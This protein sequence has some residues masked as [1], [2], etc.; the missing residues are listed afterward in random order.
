M[1]RIDGAPGQP[2][3]AA[4]APRGSQSKVSNALFF[5]LLAALLFR[6]VSGV[7]DRSSRSA[8]GDNPPPLLRWASLEKAAGEARAEGKLLL[9]DF[10][11]EWC[12]PCH[13]LDQEGWGDR[14]I[15]ALVNDSF[16]PVRVLDREREEGR[17]PPAV[18]ELE[19]RFGVEAFP[20][21][22][23]ADADGKEIARHEGWGGREGLRKFLEEAKAKALPAR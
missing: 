18:S 13:R 21:L 15:A 11:A 1:D 12:A 7:M 8:P 3:G 10:T 23:V 20:T 22:V 9:Y 6:I 19:R 14:R 17:N 16:L 4:L 2:N 5:V